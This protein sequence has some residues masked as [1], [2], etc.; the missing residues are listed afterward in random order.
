MGNEFKV[1]HGII[2]EDKGAVITGSISTNQDIS[3]SGSVTASYFSGN[4]SHLTDLSLSKSVRILIPI[5]SQYGTLYNWDAMPSASST[6]STIPR[7]ACD[8]TNIASASLAANVVTPG[9]TNSTLYIQYTTDEQSNIWDYLGYSNYTPTVAISSSGTLLGSDILL[10][11]GA[12]QPV[13]LRV[14]AVGGDGVKTPQ[15]SSV[16]LHVTYDL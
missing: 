5:M 10:N 11:S 15:L 14:M 2:V 12:R 16:T 4:G 1:K 13:I 7:I 3:A 6:S 9:A 8:L